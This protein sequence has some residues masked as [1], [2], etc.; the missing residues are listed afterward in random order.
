MYYYEHLADAKGDPERKEKL[1]RTLAR[2]QAILS[3]IEKEAEGQFY[4]PFKRSVSDL[5]RRYRR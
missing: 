4:I 3:T 2:L 5:S 1:A